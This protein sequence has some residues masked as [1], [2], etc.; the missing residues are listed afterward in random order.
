MR[1]PAAE[2]AESLDGVRRVCCVHVLSGVSLSS[3]LFDSGP[4]K[5]LISRLFGCGYPARALALSAHVPR[6]PSLCKKPPSSRRSPRGCS[7]A[8]EHRRLQCDPT[9]GAQHEPQP[10]RVPGTPL[11]VEE[12]SGSAAGQRFLLEV[13]CPG[14]AWPQLSV[15]KGREPDF[16]RGIFREGWIDAFPPARI[17]V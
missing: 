15:R 5:L 16:C 3:L 13:T 14:S 8:C 9:C 1:T 2:D 11:L 6:A 4:E 12:L 17:C 10:P 7:G